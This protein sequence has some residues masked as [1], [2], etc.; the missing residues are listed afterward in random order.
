[1]TAWQLAEA[2]LTLAG[3]PSGAPPG[4]VGA[5]PDWSLAPGLYPSERMAPKELLARLAQGGGGRCLSASHGLG[6]REVIGAA[7][8]PE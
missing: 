3:L 6:D 1:M 4:R 2:L 8:L 5:D 7:P